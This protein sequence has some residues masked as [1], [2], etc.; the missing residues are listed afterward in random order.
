MQLPPEGKTVLLGWEPGGAV[1]AVVQKL[2]GQG[3]VVM[4]MD[5]TQ[6]AMQMPAP[7]HEA[8]QVKIPAINLS[9]V[10]GEW[11]LTEINRRGQGL[12]KMKAKKKFEFNGYFEPR[13]CGGILWEPA[14]SSGDGK[15]GGDE[16]LS[17][18]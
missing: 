11:L 14:S 18:K 7:P 3:I 9:R 1:L 12:I 10:N 15:D 5:A 6:A 4:N 8:V 2:G 13:R 16:Q 17:T